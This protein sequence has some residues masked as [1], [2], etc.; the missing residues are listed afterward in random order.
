MG[1]FDDIKCEYPLPGTPLALIVPNFQTKDL[2]CSLDQYEITE[3]GRLIQTFTSFGAEPQGF[4]PY[5]GVINFYNSNGSAGA[6]GICFT[7]KG[8]DLESAEY[9]ATFKDGI[10][11]SIEQVEYS[12]EPALGYK[13]TERLLAPLFPDEVEVDESDPDVGAQM[14]IQYGGDSAGFP[15]TLAVK[16]A[17]KWALTTEDGDIETM[18]PSDLGNILFHTQAD[19]EAQRNAHTIS[20]QQRTEYCAKLLAEKIA[21]KA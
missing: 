20:W 3:D 2:E 6:Y 5:T 8:E 15:A 7:S 18:H 21:Q 17:K 10:V 4:V 16:G 14:Y 11:T 9:N 1:M 12:R 13:E 19:A